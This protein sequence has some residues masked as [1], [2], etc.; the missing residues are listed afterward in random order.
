MGL[1]YGHTCTWRFH[2]RVILITIMRTTGKFV[3]EQWLLIMFHLPYARAFQWSIHTLRHAVETNKSLNGS[4][5][6]RTGQS[7]VHGIYMSMHVHVHGGIVDQSMKY[8]NRPS[9][10]SP[11]LDASCRVSS[12]SGQIFQH[13]TLHN[14][15]CTD[16][17]SY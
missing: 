16:H 12:T 11:H 2:F 8:D 14:F 1:L 6:K 13:Q 9:V 3:C 10:A 17:C 4:E 7:S 5:N 15:S